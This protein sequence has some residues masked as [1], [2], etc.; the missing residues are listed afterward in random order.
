MHSS[1]RLMLAAALAAIVLVAAVALLSLRMGAGSGG[2]LV[3]FTAGSLRIPLEKV[4]EEYKRLHGTDVI[5]EASGSVEAIR[6]VTDLG[7][8]ADIIA[9][10]DYRLIPRFLVPRYASWYIAFA[11]NELVLVYTNHSKYHELLEKHPEEWYEILSRSDVKWGFSDPNKDP[12]G[13]RAVGAIG[14][15]SLYY[16]N[17]SILGLLTNNTNIEVRRMENGT[18]ELVVPADLEVRSGSNLVVRPKSVD[19]IALLEAGELDYAFEYRSVA[20]QHHLHYLRLPRAINLGDPRESSFYS[21][22][23]VRI[24]SGTDKETAVAMA[25]IVYGITVLDDAPHHEEAVRFLRLLLGPYGRKVFEEAGQPFLEKPLAYGRVPEELR[26]L[27]SLQG[28][29]G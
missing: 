4:A 15:A 13:Y 9:V 2:E 11:S 17:A 20:V 12:C 8:K 1:R 14:L 21:R 24:L 22:V 26:S 29:E 3:V 7:R 28:Q 18:L 5:I 23:V 27:V 19:L 25:P 16:H 6:K 10:A